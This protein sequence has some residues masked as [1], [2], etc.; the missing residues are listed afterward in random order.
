MKLK[1][2]REHLDGGLRPREAMESH[3]DMGGATMDLD[4]G[5]ELDLGSDEAA[6]DLGEHNPLAPE[7]TKPDEQFTSYEE[8]HA[9]SATEIRT[10]FMERAA[11]DQKRFE[12]A[13]DSEFWFCICF[14]SREQ[15]E[16]FLRLVQWPGV[17]EL[18]KYVH[19]EDIAKA[20]NIALPPARFTPPGEKPNK[21]MVK[22]R[23]DPRRIGAAGSTGLTT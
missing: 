9:K 4:L 15:K 13:T 7:P 1:S 10:A 19:G 8:M 14:R 22:A 20:L 16:A 18:D 21:D 2:A 5:G 3:L 17:D 6:L 23:R 11:A 12:D